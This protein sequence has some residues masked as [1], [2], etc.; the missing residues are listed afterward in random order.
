MQPP[1]GLVEKVRGLQKLK[2]IADSLPQTVRKGACQE[3]VLA[4]TRST[5]A[6]SRFSA[7]GPTT[8]RRSSRCR[9]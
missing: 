8:R 5:S 4:A 3:I 2:S 7:A 9:P 1:T 6:A